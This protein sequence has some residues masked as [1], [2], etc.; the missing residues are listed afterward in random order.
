MLTVPLLLLSNSVRVY[1]KFATGEL[2][3]CA[4]SFLTCSFSL[5]DYPPLFLSLFIS[6]EIAS[7]TAYFNFKLL[8]IIGVVN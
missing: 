1:R 7:G 6:D 5:P 4:R 8:F 2:E 3:N